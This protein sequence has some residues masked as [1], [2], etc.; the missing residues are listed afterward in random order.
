MSKDRGGF[1]G[2]CMNREVR[3]QALYW[4]S[5]VD[6]GSTAR[7]FPWW[8][9]LESATERGEQEAVLTSQQPRI[10]TK[11]FSGKSF[12][13]FRVHFIGLDTFHFRLLVLSTPSQTRWQQRLFTCKFWRKPKDDERTE[14]VP[15]HT[16]TTLKTIELSQRFVAGFRSWYSRKK[17]TFCFLPAI[18]SCRKLWYDPRLRKHP[19]LELLSGLS[20][21]LSRTA[22][23]C[24]TQM[25]AGF[26]QDFC[27]FS[28]P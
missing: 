3:E 28:L 14:L 17:G 24:L 15:Y 4:N 6:L 25:A 11:S 1:K 27:L 16:F 20:V 23:N 10:I 12:W 21:L 19:W 8:T 5:S 22:V 26:C 13:T 9:L 7:K 18:R 2:R